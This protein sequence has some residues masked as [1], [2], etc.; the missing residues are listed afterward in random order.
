MRVFITAASQIS[1]IGVSKADVISSFKALKTGVV[2]EDFGELGE[3]HVGRIDKINEELCLQYDIPTGLSRTTIL[4]IVAI[5]ELMDNFIDSNKYS[6]LRSCLINGTSV[7]GMDYTEGSILNYLGGDS[8]NKT[9]F[10]NHT[11]G[12]ITKELMKNTV[13]VDMLDTI[14]TACSSAANAIIAGVEHIKSGNYDLAIVGGTDSLSRF[15]IKGFDSLGIYDRER[16]RPFDS[17]R[18]GINLGEG[19][20]YILLESEESIS[21]SGNS[22]LV[23]ITGWG[24]VSDAHHQT[25]SSPEGKGAT[26]AM[27]KAL[28]QANL[29]PSDIDF[30]NTHGTATPNND[31]T[32]SQALINVFGDN[33]PLFSSTKAFTGHTLAASSGIEV[34]YSIYSMLEGFTMPNL[35]CENTIEETNLTPV[36]KFEQGVEID[37]LLSNA[38]GFGGNCTSLVFSKVK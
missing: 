36:K 20:G 24:S 4:G 30:I 27:T 38:F 22:P 32:E 37:H 10:L 31:V 35:G 29:D 11:C 28:N 21:K 3:Y 6:G 19:A 13:R 17:S 34:V 2:K 33:V 16:C 14:S 25:A 5:K 26:L 8:L 7:G 18:N 1:P 23:E 9:L 15:T 12:S